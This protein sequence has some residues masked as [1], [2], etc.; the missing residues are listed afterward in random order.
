MIVSKKRLH[1]FKL[2]FLAALFLSVTGLLSQNNSDSLKILLPHATGLQKMAILNSLVDASLYNNLDS[3][4][5]YA[6]LL[7]KEGEKTRNI[8]YRSLALRAL[9]ICNFYKTNYY[10]A[11]DYILQAVA[12]QK[13]NHDSSGLANSYKVLTGIYWETER[14]QKSVAI[15]F[16]ALKIYEHAGDKKGV[17]S[18]YNNIGL[19]YKRL[20]EPQKALTYFQNALKILYDNPMDYNSGNLYNNTGLVYKEL[21]KYD[22][23]KNYYRKALGEYK[24]SGLKGGIATVY[25]N[26][27][28]LYA[29]YLNNLDSA[30]Y[31]YR[32]GLQLADNTDYTIVSDIYSGLASLYSKNGDA[33]QSINALNKALALAKSY[34][35]ADLQKDIQYDLY[36]VF[37]KNGQNG[38]ALRHL[39]NYTAIK[40][41]L[42]EK[43]AK[44]T[45]ANLEAKFENE[46][47]KILIRKMQEKQV[48]DKWIKVLL[49]SGL[50]LLLLSIILL[51]FSFKQKRKKSRLQRELLEAEKKQLENDLQ[52]NRR[53]L[54]TQALMMMKKNR[55]LK[56]ITRALSVIKNLP[57]ESQ[58]QL[59]QLQKQLKKGI[60]S[61]EDWKMFQHYFEEVNPG[62][63]VKLLDVNN[64]ITPSEQKLA[65]LVKLNFSIKETASLL[66]ISP[67]SVKT[68]RSVLRKKLY[69]QKGDN[70]YDFLNGL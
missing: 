36:H 23:A 41:T 57:A 35:D 12:L 19:L 60:H 29:Y 44:V 26:M 66:N 68:I 39:E 15:S 5:F 32:N 45:I 2:S 52:F 58:Q 67:D 46:K 6:G 16:K 65:S 49:L 27:G 9:G 30:F 4:C 20:D 31:Y 11:E 40:D 33:M 8:R 48:V 10:K 1:Y 37:K 55:L 21:K 18:S 38:K 56:E 43:Q 47:N 70:I 13:S 53:Q 24:K 42:T 54:T 50:G 51:S 61:E 25:L 63:F 17:V 22:Q 14:Y 64:K 59:L 62:F 7:Q 34:G 3:A 69:L 28:N